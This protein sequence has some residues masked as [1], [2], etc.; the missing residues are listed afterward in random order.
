MG[1]LTEP[2]FP[3]P[4]VSGK[5]AE[6][7]MSF[8]D[9]GSGNPSSGSVD[10]I[11]VRYCSLHNITRIP[12]TSGAIFSQGLL[13]A[14]HQVALYETSQSILEIEIRIIET[15]LG[16]EHMGICRIG[17]FNFYASSQVMR[18]PR[19]RTRSRVPPSQYP[20]NVVTVPYVGLQSTANGLT[21][22]FYAGVYLGS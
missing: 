14:Q 16:G 18:V 13:D 22:A 11:D 21:K 10:A 5:E 19:D 9:A 20:R 12:M 8:V 17:P 7:G 6:Q 1:T 4:H 3:L 15:A 2:H